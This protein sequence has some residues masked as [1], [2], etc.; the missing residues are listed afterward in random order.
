MAKALPSYNIDSWIGILN[1]KKF[2]VDID[3]E[4]YYISYPGFPGDS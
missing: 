3:E 2:F 4:I 1:A